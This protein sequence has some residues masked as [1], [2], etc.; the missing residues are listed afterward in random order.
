MSLAHAKFFLRKKKIL[1]FPLHFLPVFCAQSINTLMYF[2]KVKTHF[3][4]L[5][6]FKLDGKLAK[7]HGYSVHA[8]Q[9]LRIGCNA[10]GFEQ[11]KIHVQ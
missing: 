1:F 6:L 11:V 9:H 3:P 4:L 10:S 7:K 5:I 2:N 8:K